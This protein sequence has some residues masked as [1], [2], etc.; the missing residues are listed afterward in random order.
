MDLHKEKSSDE[1]LEIMKTDVYSGKI[2]VQSPMGKIIDFPEGSTPID[3]AYAIHSNIGNS[4]VGAKINGEIKPLRSVLQNGDQVEVLTSKAQHPS[5]EWERF[6]VTGKAKAAIRRYVRACKREQFLSLGKDILEKL[7]KQE[8]LDFNEKAI[9]GTLT[10]FD[11][12]SLDDLYAKV[13]EGLVTGWDVLRT[14]YPAYKQSKITQV[15]N[16]ITLSKPA[17]LLFINSPDLR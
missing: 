14:V 10:Q 7:F 1:L 6:V 13:G 5:T 8:S 12:E 17:K 9:Y 15:V 11:C 3:F 2:F 4:C 16:S